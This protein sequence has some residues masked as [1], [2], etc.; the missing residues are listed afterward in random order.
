MQLA[1]KNGKLADTYQVPETARHNTPDHI[2]KFISYGKQKGVFG[3]FALGS[4]F[5]PVEQKIVL[6]LEKIQAV[7]SDPSLTGKLKLVKM[8]FAGFRVNAGPFK[9]ELSRMGFEKTTGL[10]Q[11]IYLSLLLKALSTK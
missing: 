1:K 4:D 10:M 9:A 7:A 5:T 8:I 11:K 6:A 2:K 3:S